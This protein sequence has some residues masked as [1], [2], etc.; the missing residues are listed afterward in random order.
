MVVR[1][2]QITLRLR[3]A[4]DRKKLT[5]LPVNVVWA[6]EEGTTPPKEDPLDWLLHTNHRVDSFADAEVV[7]RG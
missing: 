2:A 3:D 7:L 1:V 4:S 5:L 6:R